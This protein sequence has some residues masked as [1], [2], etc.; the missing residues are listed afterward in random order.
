MDHNILLWKSSLCIEYMHNMDDLHR[1]DLNLL[2]TLHALLEER[3]VTRAAVRLNKSQPAVSRAL[4]Q[5]REYFDD[6]LLRRNSGRF[7]L[8]ARARQLQ[9]PLQEAL[10]QLGDL[11]SKAPFDPTHARRQFRL[12]LSDYA[13]RIVLPRLVR[14]IRH[15]APAVDL[16]IIQG[17]S[18]EAMI[19]QLIDGELDIALG[20]F[21]ERPAE[22]RVEA[23][24][25]ET[26]VSVADRHV[27]PDNGTMGLE[28][29]LA[30][31]HVMLALRPDAI[32][33]I[34][35]ELLA[36]GLRRRIA[37]ALPHWSA[38]LDLM[39]GT[40]LILTVASR[41]TIDLGLHPTLRIFAPPFALPG[42]QYQQ[43]WHARRDGDP[44]HVWL[45]QA[46]AECVADLPDPASDDRYR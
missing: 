1:V 31:P 22:I 41:A 11:L 2:L 25:D 38:A 34:D 23:L 15:Y 18:R 42:F 37:L 27:V 29:W 39:D 16:A 3:H 46:V 6:P 28:D 21:P 4:A 36:R 30:R 35:K 43:A 8:T 19:G 13:A 5:L 26:F 7:E 24:F 14:H 33:E 12:A 32:D 45:R 20:I 17:S 10:S 44:G 9:R 40:D